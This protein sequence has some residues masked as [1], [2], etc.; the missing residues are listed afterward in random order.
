MLQKYSYLLRGFGGEPRTDSSLQR[1]EEFVV[2]LYGVDGVTNADKARHVLFG[3]VRKPELIP[4]SS[5]ALQQHLLRAH[6]QVRTFKGDLFTAF[7]PIKHACKLKKK[8]YTFNC[9][10]VQTNVWLTAN[11]TTPSLP[12][13]TDCGWRLDDNK[14]VPVLST[15]EAVPEICRSL[16]CCG[17]KTGCKTKLC[18]CHRT[19]DEHGVSLPCTNLCKCR[20]QCSN[21]KDNCEVVGESSDE[22]PDDL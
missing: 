7:F 1:A 10:F 19:K 18:K 3:K 4:A 8:V 2:Q 13:V 11:E 15:L 9:A 6:Y 21:G 12:N 16:V 5:D 20:G 17:C 22:D 14:L